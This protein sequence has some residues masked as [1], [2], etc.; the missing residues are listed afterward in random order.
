MNDRSMQERPVAVVLEEDPEAAAT[1]SLQLRLLGME[2]HYCP[3]AHPLALMEAV[4]TRQPRL[5]VVGLEVGRQDGIAMLRCLAEHHYPGRV[6]LLSGV[7][8]RITRIAERLGRH[9]GLEMLAS[10]DKPLH[11]QGLRR[12]L[13]ALAES[14][15]PASSD[16]TSP[17]W[18]R[19]GLEHAFACHELILH[20]QPQFELATGRLSGVEALVR[21][22]H[23]TVGLLEPD[24]FLPLLTA[25]QGRFLT[26]RVLQLAMA[27]AAAWHRAGLRLS[28]SVNVTPDDL[29]CPDLPAM[30]WA[31]RTGLGDMP[32]V[33][34]IT[35]TAAM[36][37][38]LLG[39]EAAARLHLSGLEV[40]VDDFGVGF[41]SLAR[42][43]LMP[44][45]ELKVD[46]SFVS[47]LHEDPLDAAI[48]EAVA[49]LGRRLGIRVVAEGV[50]DLAVL[51]PLARLG[52]THVQGFGLARPVAADEIPDLVRQP[53]LR[54]AGHSFP[55][56]SP[57]GT[58]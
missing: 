35:E 53:L 24:A 16:D 1:L 7:E 39:S 3:H 10:L 49:L 41:S 23:P 17:G 50:E 21:W 40:S 52:C 38:E 13:D 46:R 4:W 27:D 54:R 48:V 51:A 5:V 11:L 26:R 22:A 37:D 19:G 18:R 47:R 43:Q 42:L 56:A 45:S 14:A 6:L 33:L 25:E 31:G 8:R 9:L 29:V 15:P 30:V 12:Q 20:Y 55:S 34:E 44:I 57:D 32:V 2:M 58:P 36:E 28:L